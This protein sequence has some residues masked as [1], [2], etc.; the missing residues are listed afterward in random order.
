LVLKKDIIGEKQMT[1]RS[2]RLPTERKRSVTF[3]GGRQQVPGLN[4]LE[5]ENDEKTEAG[6]DPLTYREEGERIL[7]EAVQRS[8][9]SRKLEEHGLMNGELR[10]LYEMQLYEQRKLHDTV[11]DVKKQVSRVKERNFTS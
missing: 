5:E 7:D 9:M 6:V 3:E 8:E 4:L 2:T 1:A 11:N 10:D